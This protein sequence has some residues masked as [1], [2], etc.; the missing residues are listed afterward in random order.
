MNKLPLGLKSVLLAITLVLAGNSSGAAVRADKGGN[1]VEVK[2]LDMAMQIN[3]L[4]VEP[5]TTVRWINLD[6][7]DHDVT[8]GKVATGREARRMKETRF[9]DGRF[10]SGLFGQG[11]VFEFT[12]AKEGRDA[13]YCGIHP[14]MTAAVI[15]EA[16]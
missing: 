1:A 11:R 4:S 12:F 8:S 16:R 7:F 14:M 13:Y 6:P 5:G 3:E 15:V 2:I 9:P 10:P